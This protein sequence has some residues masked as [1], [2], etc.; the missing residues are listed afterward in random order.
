M[1][2]SEIVLKKMERDIFRAM[3][4]MAAWIL[5]DGDFYT[6]N[7]LPVMADSMLQEYRHLRKLIAPSEKAN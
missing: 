4:I 7:D 2:S 1:G 3:R 5:E 6:I